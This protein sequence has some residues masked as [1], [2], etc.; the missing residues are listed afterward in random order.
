ME[1]LLDG[2]PCSRQPQARGQLA[3]SYTK[4][5]S[6]VVPTATACGSLFEKAEI[7]S[8]E[9]LSRFDQDE[10]VGLVGQVLL[11]VLLVVVLLERV[12]DFDG[13][14]VEVSGVG[15]CDPVVCVDLREGQCDVAIVEV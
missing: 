10:A 2:V 13:V 9:S 8:S 4:R 11:Q 5:R 12:T 14:L 15:E 1:S 3:G 6:W 7:G